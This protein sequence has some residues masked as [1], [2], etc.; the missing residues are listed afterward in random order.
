MRSVGPNWI[1]PTCQWMKLTSRLYPCRQ[2]RPETWCGQ[3]EQAFPS[4]LPKGSVVELGRNPVFASPVE[5]AGFLR[6]VLR[7][8]SRLQVWTRCEL[9]LVWIQSECRQLQKRRGNR[10]E[11]PL[12]RGVDGED[13]R[14]RLRVIRVQ[15]D[16]LRAEDVLDR[17]EDIALAVAL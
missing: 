15:V 9:D 17:A 1:P 11:C 7:V 2:R 16:V 5:A 14:H 12:A 10:V 8:M 3:P 13:I 6:P 4:D